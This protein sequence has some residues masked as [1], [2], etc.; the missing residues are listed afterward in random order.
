MQLFADPSSVTGG[1]EC[2]SILGP[3]LGGGHGFLQGRH[4]LISDQFVSMNIVDA[5]GNLKT[6]T[7]DSDPDL[8]WAMQGAGHNFGIV[9][10]VTSKIHDI[11]HKDWAYQSFV[12]TGDKVE[13]LYQNINE[14]LLKNGTQ[15]VDVI[16]YSFFINFPAAD[17]DK[18]SETW[19]LDLEISFPTSLAKLHHIAQL[20]ALS[21]S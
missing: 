18:V 16:N 11:V 13:G 21:L 14:K 15:L 2:T 17:P 9:T 6:L 7:K 3:G 20:T 5:D 10:S 12:F 19:H 8:W 4:G 1:C